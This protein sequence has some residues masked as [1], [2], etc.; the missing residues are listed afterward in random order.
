MEHLFTPSVEPPQA[1]GLLICSGGID[2]SVLLHV[3][4]REQKIDEVMLLD[5]GQA[6]ADY[7]WACVI[8]QANKANIHARRERIDWPTYAQGKG[9]IFR[10]GFYPE[11]MED[12]YEPV[13]MTAEE[14]D[15]YLEEKWDFI[16]GRNIVFLA[17]ACAYAIS[18]KKTI[19][20]TAFQFDQPEWDAM[21]EHGCNGSDTSPGF[22]E[23]F[24]RLAQAGGFTKRIRVEAPFLDGRATKQ[25]IVD[26]G[27]DLGV[28][29]E[30]TYSCEFF[31]ACGSCHQCLI[32][33]KVLLPRAT[34]KRIF[35]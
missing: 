7:Q 12:P 20:Y 16:Q 19:V 31:P 4:A 24:N 32:R 22:T 5:Y 10:E 27:R 35:F 15:R 2:S 26:L 25:Q 6:S 23:A 30:W 13:T 14:Y 21:P 34:P 17:R 8:T 11:G 18:R 33:Q 29:L 28:D 3:L 9:Y 1:D